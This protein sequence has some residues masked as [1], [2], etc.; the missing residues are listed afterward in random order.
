LNTPILEDY[1]ID[2]KVPVEYDSR[3]L[4][5]SMPKIESKWWITTG[6]VV[7]ALV[8]GST[9]TLAWEFSRIDKHISRVETA[10]RIVGAKQG[11]DTKTLIDE[12]LTVAKNASDAGR[13][14]S[15]RA[16]LD[17]ANRLLAEQQASRVEAPQEFFDSAIQ[18]YQK[19]KKSPELSDSVWDG[20]V[21][22]AEYR[23]AITTVPAGSVVR[24]G[25]IGQKGSFRYLKDSLI[26]G[27]DAIGIGGENG[28]VLDGFYLQNDIFENA[29]I[30]YHGGPVML[31]NVRFVNCRF[32]V[33]R[34]AQAEQL[35]EAAIKQPI[36]AFV[37]S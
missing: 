14:T 24:I 7:I 36:L 17:I 1:A 25:A 8:G 11:G 32:Q 27:P 12:A 34:S 30:I 23:S 28:F 37:G 4:G 2:L 20:T 21:K 19:L 31:Q 16:V 10:V 35:M 6:L 3:P 9:W 5:E 33:N 15:A 18:K 29:T 26:S 22:L 13:D